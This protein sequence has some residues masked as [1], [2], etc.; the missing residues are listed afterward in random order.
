MDQVKSIFPRAELMAVYVAYAFR[1][2]YPLL[3]LP[4][5]GR[6]LGAGGYGVVLAG[7]SLSNSIWLFVN[8]GFSTV[9]ARDAVQ[10]RDARTRASIL[11]DHLTARLVLS[12]PGL[13]VGLIA[14]HFSLVFLHRPAV[15][16]VVVFLG[17]L[18][19]FN[20][21][22]YF[23]STGRAR[24]SVLI[25]VAGF[26]TSLALIFGFVHRPSDLAYVFPLLLISC[27]TQLIIAYWLVR[28]EFS[29]L[30]SRLKDAI[31]LIRKSTTIFI[32]GGTSVLLIGA[33]TYIL[34]MLARESEVSAFGVAERLIAAGLSLMAPAAQILVPRVTHLVVT[35][36]SRANRLTRQIFAWFFAGAV[37]ATLLTLTFADW[38]IPLV[39][40]H[41]FQQTAGVLKLMVFVFPVSVCTQVLG[42]YFLIP[43]KLERLL[44]RAGVVS[45]VVNIAVAV[46]LAT[47]WGAMGMA[48]ARLVGELTMLTVLVAGMHRSNLLSELFSV[49]PV[50]VPVH[51]FGEG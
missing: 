17:L 33:S 15:G 14:I 46:P 28:K 11:S 6:V 44:A 37:C 32:Y 50:G 12:L 38:F 20:L 29:H 30:F 23:T 24:T 31:N 47:H 27:A 7:M 8:F 13:I 19:A 34:S 49:E 5:Y 10:A 9:G 39:F 22:W 2:L 51:E 41:G 16:C 45:A 1:Y 18:A 48:T 43:R 25:E 40:G 35:D 21:G 42:M 36:P 26:S 3:L 4:Y